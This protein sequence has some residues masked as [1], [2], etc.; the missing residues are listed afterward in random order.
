MSDPNETY[1]PE[2]TG[3][4]DA[5]NQAQSGVFKNGTMDEARE[6][7]DKAQED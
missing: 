4:D 1:Q 6:D 7:S 2:L 3:F 5:M